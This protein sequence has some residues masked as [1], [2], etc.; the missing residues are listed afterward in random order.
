MTRVALDSNILIYAKVEPESDKGKSASTLIVR[1]AKDGVIP[2]QVTGEFLRFFQR[3][4]PQLFDEAV[5]LLSI[6]KATFHMPVTTGDVMTTAAELVQ[7]HRLQL[8][9]AVVCAA[10]AAAGAK[11]LFSEDMQDGRILNGLRI[12]NP[13]DAG[14]SD[15]IDALLGERGGST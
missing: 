15:L 13:F 5:L 4:T 7:A 6:Y 11:V 8:W 2:V 3:R 1:V 12:V 9:D 14:N 10:S